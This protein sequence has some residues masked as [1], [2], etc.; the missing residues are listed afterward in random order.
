M[1]SGRKVGR[2]ALGNNSGPLHRA[3]PAYAVQSVPTVVGS[4]SVS[5]P[6]DTYWRGSA[7]K[8]QAADATPRVVTL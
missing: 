7:L 4:G 6:K 2:P 8:R 1:S 5:R 3:R